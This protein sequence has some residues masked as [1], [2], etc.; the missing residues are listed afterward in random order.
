MP[1]AA[2][3]GVTASTGTGPVR[4]IPSQSRDGLSKGGRS[5]CPDRRW[6]RRRDA[7][8]DP[9]RLGSRGV[10]TRGVR[11]MLTKA[12][13]TMLRTVPRG[14]R[15]EVR[16]STPGWWSLEL[17]SGGRKGCRQHAGEASQTI[18]RAVPRGVRGE[19]PNAYQD[20]TRFDLR[21]MVPECA[22]MLPKDTMLI[23][24]GLPFSANNL[25]QSFVDC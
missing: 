8:A 20:V 22:R 11:S 3:S 9:L 15:N 2:F 14:V 18:L 5:M 25:H 16:G 1:S 24:V 7:C 13:R 17:G 4:S 10:V 12:F 23:V 6:K 19:M 21:R